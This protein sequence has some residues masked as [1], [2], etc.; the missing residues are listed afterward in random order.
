[1]PNH[2]P[3]VSEIE[4][5]LSKSLNMQNLY[6]STVASFSNNPKYTIE[7]IAIPIVYVECKEFGVIDIIGDIKA[8]LSKLYNYAMQIY[9]KPMWNILNK[10]IETIKEI[11]SIDI[12][13]LINLKLPILDLDVFDMFNE[14][15]VIDAVKAKVT[16]LWN[17]SKEKL[18]E[19][20]KLLD[21]P[22]PPFE[23]VENPQR[24]I[25]QIID[26]IM[27]SLWSTVFKVIEKI[28]GAIKTALDLWDRII[29]KG[30]TIFGL[31]WQEAIDLVFGKLLDLLINPPTM[32]QIKQWIIEF[33][34]GI[35]GKAV[36]TYEEIMAVIKDFKIP[37]LDIKPY[38][39]E[40]PYNPHLSVP[41]LDFQQLLVDIKTWLNNY[42]VSIIKDF[43]NKIL[44]FIKKIIDGLDLSFLVLK[45]PCTFCAVQK[46][47]T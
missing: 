22:W 36:V 7:G 15:K 32:E 24:I 39:W 21:I 23:N 4:I 40:L 45:I 33:A 5:D 9:F 26:S 10:I 17:T 1:M 37:I 12:L 47:L 18:Q 3:I 20:L 16:E 38:D 42:V 11:L 14:N 13:K 19:L 34:K 29:N 46:A 8:A 2:I 43:V 41:D 28:V 6:E 25:E 44:E 31:L 30:L 35:Y 27:R